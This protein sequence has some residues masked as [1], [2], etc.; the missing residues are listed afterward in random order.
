MERWARINFQPSIP[1]GRD[2]KNVTASDAHISLARRAAADGMVLLKNDHNVL[3][4]R[5][6]TKIAL[7]GRGHIDYIK[8]GGGSGSVLSPYTRNIYE[9]LSLK[10]Q[11]GKVVL[12]RELSEYYKTALASELDYLNSLDRRT[13]ARERMENDAW[14]REPEIPQELLQR[15]AAFTDTAILT[16]SRFSS[17][18]YERRAEKGDYYLSSDEEKLLSR[19]KELFRHVIIILNIGG[20]SDVSWFSSDERIE[21]ALL[22]WQSGME[23]GLA[24]ADV[25]CG[26]VNPSGRLTDTFAQSYSDYPSAGTFAESD[27]YVNYYEDIYN[28]Y[29]YF[30]TIPGAREKVIYPF[31]FGLSYTDFTISFGS[32]LEAKS[33][34]SAQVYVKN[35]G[36]RPGK[37]VVQIYAETPQGLLGKAKLVLC[38]FAK[39]RLLIPGE[40]EKLAV[41]INLN[42]LASY[43]D[44]GTI[45]QSAY[46]LEKGEYRFYGG[47][48]V[49]S[50]TTFYSVRIEKDLVVRLC[51]PRAVPVKLP[52]RLKADGSHEQLPERLPNLEIHVPKELPSAKSDKL[53]TLFDVAAGQASVDDIIS[54]MSDKEL[55]SL[56]YGR[57]TISVSPTNGI[58]G[59]GRKS[60]FA[61][62]LVPTADGP[63]GLRIP[64]EVGLSATAFPC[65][66]QLACTWDT[67]LVHEVAYAMAEEVKENNIGIFL[68]PA[69]NIHRDPL[70][71]RNFEY[72]SED[73]FLT[74]KMAAAAVSG[75][76]KNGIAATVK[77]FACYGKE[78]NRRESDSRVSE[79]ALR[80]IYLRGF[81][82]VVREAQPWALMT[83]YNLVNG[84]RAS[85]NYDLITGILRG[86][87]GFQ[88][89][90]MTDWHVIGSHIQELL[91]GSDVK[92]PENL[93][94]PENEFSDLPDAIAKGQVPRAIA[95]QSAKRV[96][97]MILKLD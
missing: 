56:L 18:K 15:A 60:R 37:Q 76:Q 3:P 58:G 92:M 35:T 79:R 27:E 14:S 12:F 38:G 17:E 97:E 87:W 46:V 77:H 69:L 29:R 1:L 73:P 5:P 52:Y 54:A 21:G 68:A 80:E 31:G 32:V 8:G 75:I 55:T 96:L 53:V 6:G 26:D 43:D 94:K 22:A 74:G 41:S 67:A 82:I 93:I 85:Q 72:Y 25:L 19:I 2:G 91:A 65:A 28:G 49:R 70:C 51:S 39:T 71:G 23:G 4:L 24:V 81:E 61:I 84:I 9:G 48:N 11:E 40:E 50:L 86:E 59:G 13:Y 44:C 34:I 78:T 16:I 66:T 63:A 33:I 10:A 20:V 42:D 57:E 83:S 88:G 30:E 36:D 45:R 95:Q 64:L 90:V 47:E 89:L 7:F 62:P